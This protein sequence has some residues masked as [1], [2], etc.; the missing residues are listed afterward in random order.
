MAPRLLAR[1]KL[2]NGLSLEFWDESRKL[3]GDRWYVAVRAVVPVPFAEYSPKA[4][5]AAVMELILSEVGEDLCFQL[6]EERNFIVET[7]MEALR[8]ELQEVLAKNVLSYL[9]RPDFPSRFVARKVWEVAEKMGWGQEH[10]QRLLDGLR[11]PFSR[12]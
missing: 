10:L 4:V 6:M 3:A 5:P 11:R 1:S 8:G 12:R 2:P 7:E 9:S